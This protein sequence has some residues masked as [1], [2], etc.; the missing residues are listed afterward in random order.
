M[1]ARAAVSVMNDYPVKV[2]IPPLRFAILVPNCQPDEKYLLIGDAKTDVAHVMPKQF[3][4]INVVGQ[5][6]Q[7][8]ESLTTA[9]PASHRSP[10]DSLLAEYLQ[11]NDTTVFVR[12]NNGQD[13]DTPDWMTGILKDTTVPFPL[14]GHPFDNLIRNF[15]LT[16]VH[17]NL[18]DPLS[19]PDSPGSQPRISATVNAL[20]GLP[21]EM[22]FDLDV[23]RVRTEAD[24]FYHGKKLGK[25]DMLKWQEAR[26]SK[27]GS[28][29]L[30]ESDIDK[31]PLRIEDDDVFTEVIEALVFS[32][33]GVVL[34]VKA[35]VN[36]NTVT[37]LGEFVVREIPAEGGVFVKPLTLS[38]LKPQIGQL[39]VVDTSKSSVT[40]QARVN[41]SN[42]TDYSAHIPFMNI[43][44]S[45]ND[46]VLG[47]GI[48][49]DVDVV[50]GNNTNLLVNA[51]W[52][53]ENDTVG[54]QFLSQY[55]SGLNTTLTLRTHEASI[56][57]QPALGRALS[58]LKIVVDTPDLFGQKTPGHS[59]P[60]F[61]DDATV[62][63]SLLS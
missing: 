40:L 9:C 25:L 51:L 37:A 2:D 1:L 56:P 7:L 39:R 63:P 6:Q 19:E 34:T 57:T 42:P 11:G 48:A 32:G 54:R 23:D 31:A 52:M 30:I 17:F 35:L 47:Y 44:M 22:N 8:P 41:V 50:P 16:N 61:I 24:I 49:K 10:L 3:V 14:P 38:K 62:L 26:T 53:P 27:V 58:G 21:K 28:D 20:V 45:N 15:S 46:T 13:R 59:G 36:V 60:S 33:K 12:G 4:D 29:L 55:I 43:S 5:I 18:P